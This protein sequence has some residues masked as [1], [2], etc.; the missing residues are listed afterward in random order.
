MK[1]LV[2]GA[3]GFLGKKLVARLVS[4]GFEVTALYYST[5]LDFKH[6]KLKW[7]KINLIDNDFT[8]P[9][10]DSIVH[11]AGSTHSSSKENSEYFYYNDYLTF[12][13]IEK[14][15]PKIKRF[16]FASSQSVYGEIRNGSISENTKAA[17]TINAYGYSKINAE[18]WIKFAQKNTNGLYLSLRFTGFIDGG[19]LIDYII[20][21]A[22][23]NLEIELLSN[24]SVKRDYIHSKNA[25]EAII[26]AL[27]KKKQ[28]LYKNINIGSGQAIKSIDIARFICQ[29]LKSRSIIKLSK[30]KLPLEYF[31]FN[32]NTAKNFL[33]YNPSDTLADIN[34]YLDETLINTKL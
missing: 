3:S 5:K 11:L 8:W 34:S 19:G 10:V 23:N 21:Q 20:N 6:P 2:T 15:P 25:V 33:G 12:K 28:S 31:V 13:L 1:V 7:L 24:G 14:I 27:R 32:I 9:D 30:K 17:N 18:N 16:I 22:K 29:K 4:L 26:L